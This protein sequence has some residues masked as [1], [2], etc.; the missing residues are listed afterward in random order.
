MN[1]AHRQR[2]RRAAWAFN[3]TDSGRPLRSFPILTYGKT[4]TF[5]PLPVRLERSRVLRKEFVPYSDLAVIA[6]SSFMLSLTRSALAQCLATQLKL[7]LASLPAAPIASEPV[8]HLLASHPGLL[9]AL[10]LLRPLVRSIAASDLCT[11]RRSRDPYT[12]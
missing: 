8:L 12:P 1:V 2:H 4:R 6:L 10:L 11:R 9:V 7:S 3:S 5:F